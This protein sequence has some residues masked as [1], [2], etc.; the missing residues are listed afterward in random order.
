MNKN[1][2]LEIQ[3]RSLKLLAYDH[4]IAVQEKLDRDLVAFAVRADREGL[5]RRQRIK[6]MNEIIEE[7][8]QR[9]QDGLIIATAKDI[10]ANLK[11][12]NKHLG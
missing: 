4:E 9:S 10:L 1:L 11:L 12:T 2:L 8:F 6:A 5:T 3:G 7:S